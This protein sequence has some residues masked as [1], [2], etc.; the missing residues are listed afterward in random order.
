MK[1]ATCFEEIPQEAV[2]EINFLLGDT[3]SVAELL[4]PIL[5]K[6]GL[7][8]EKGDFF[9][10]EAADEPELAVEIFNELFCDF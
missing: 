6:N 7:E 1:K 10:F 8:C 5:E 4:K 9:I 2:D 3:I